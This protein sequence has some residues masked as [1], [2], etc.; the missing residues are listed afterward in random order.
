L[1]LLF[2]ATLHQSC[3]SSIEDTHAIDID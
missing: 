1:P 3:N 2:L